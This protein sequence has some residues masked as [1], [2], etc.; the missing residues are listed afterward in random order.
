MVSARVD[1]NL[2]SLSIYRFIFCVG[3]CKHMERALQWIVVVAA[4]AS[5]STI[6]HAAGID[7]PSQRKLANVDYADVIRIDCGVKEGYTDKTRMQ[8]EDDDIQYGEI[9]TISSNDT[10]QNQPQIQKQLISLRS[11]PEGKRNCYTLKPREGKNKRYIVRSYFA[12]GN[13]DNK[14]KPPT[15]DLYIDVTRF[16]F[17]HFTVANTT[18]RVEAIYFSLTDTIDLCLVN[19][20]QGIPF[21]SLLELWPLGSAN[22]YQD[23]LNLQTQDLLTRVTLGV[24]SA[25]DQLLRSLGFKLHI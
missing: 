16:T 4:C 2:S 11:F 8:Y 7:E 14:S 18:R 25:K 12:Y 20:E 6:I 22:V 9:H 13:Y 19:V 5:L 23:L 21:I 24:S 17:I 3:R 10:L 1:F 15:F